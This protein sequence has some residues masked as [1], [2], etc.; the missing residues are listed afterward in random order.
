MLLRAAIP[1]ALTTYQSVSFNW[2]QCTNIEAINQ[3]MLG[4]RAFIEQ[5]IVKKESEEIL[6]QRKLKYDS[7]LSVRFASDTIARARLCSGQITLVRSLR[8]GAVS[9][10]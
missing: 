6:S 1:P 5:F 10:S 2:L 3:P 7:A 4:L 8:F 9:R